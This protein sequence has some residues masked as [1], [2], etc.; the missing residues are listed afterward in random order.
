[1][2]GLSMAL[3]IGLAM[4]GWAE[5]Q[6]Y[7]PDAP[8]ISILY[9]Y[10]K[11]NPQGT[12]Q[13]KVY[14][15]RYP[16]GPVRDWMAQNKIN[17]INSNL[18]G[19][20]FD[21]PV[22]IQLSRYPGYRNGTMTKEDIVRAVEER[23]KRNLPA[24]ELAYQR[25]QPVDVKPHPSE[26]PKVKDEASRFTYKKEAPKQVG[27]LAGTTWVRTDDPTT[28]RFLNNGTVEMHTPD[29]G[30]VSA[31][32]LLLKY[33]QDG[34]TVRMTSSPDKMPIKIVT[35]GDL[36]N[37]QELSLEDG[38]PVWNWQLRRTSP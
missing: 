24:P 17:D 26:Q 38:R 9:W 37:C 18:R 19:C 27:S 22:R 11:T 2:L 10:D 34:N 20:P 12:I 23:V 7:R 25:I 8:D 32:V 14:E 30:Y 35:N 31:G 6:D 3:G 36:M 13:F 28:F 15:G 21:S 4:P 33:Q 1:M 29:R 5:A 16:Q